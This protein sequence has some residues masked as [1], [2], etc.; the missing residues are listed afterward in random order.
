[1]DYLDL[2]SIAKK[3]NSL[4]FAVQA[5]TK[6]K[7]KKRFHDLSFLSIKCS[8]VEYKNCIKH[9]EKS[10]SI[11]ENPEAEEKNPCSGW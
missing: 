2:P 1:M 5:P 11:K 9:E 3:Q 4:Y 6:T 8:L 7:S 10:I